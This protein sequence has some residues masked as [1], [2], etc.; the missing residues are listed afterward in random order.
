MNDRAS[1]PSGARYRVEQG[2]DGSWLIVDHG[3]DRGQR[4]AISWSSSEAA[5]RQEADTLSELED[6]TSTLQA[7][8]SEPWTEI[9]RIVAETTAT[10]DAQETFNHLL[11]PTD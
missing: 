3:A 7:P 6:I 4:T 10:I 5:A 11:K 8:T 9:D 1:A 2:T